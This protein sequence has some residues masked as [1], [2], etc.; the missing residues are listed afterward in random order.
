MSGEPDAMELGS[1]F[2]EAHFSGYPI[3]ERDKRLY[4]PEVSRAWVANRATAG[5][6]LKSV[7]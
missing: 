1:D 7:Y 2:F 5:S 3:R 4:S 6:Q